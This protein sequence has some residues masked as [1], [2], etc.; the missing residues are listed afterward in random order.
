MSVMLLVVVW[1]PVGGTAVFAAAAVV[2]LASVKEGTTLL[3]SILSL[4]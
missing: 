3:S 2:P 4:L 1:A